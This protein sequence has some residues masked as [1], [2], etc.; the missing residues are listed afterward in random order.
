M[1]PSRSLPGYQ[2]ALNHAAD[3][4]EVLGQDWDRRAATFR[5]TLE[6]N[7]F[8][9]NSG[10]MTPIDPIVDLLDSGIGDSANGNN[11]VNPTKC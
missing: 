6:A 2:E 9:V 8:I 4:T 11:E 10:Q 7:G 3:A 1:E 5:A